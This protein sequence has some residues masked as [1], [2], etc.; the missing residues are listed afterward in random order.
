MSEAQQ[1]QMGYALVG[2]ALLR[3]RQW[4]LTMRLAA[5]ALYGVAAG[6]LL[7]DGMAADLH[8]RAGRTTNARRVT[9]NVQ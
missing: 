7:R 8:P 6:L 1:Q 4:P 3:S 5:G 9:A 2:A